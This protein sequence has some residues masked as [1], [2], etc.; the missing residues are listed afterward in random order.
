MRVLIALL[1][2]VNVAWADEWDQEESDRYLQRQYDRIDSIFGKDRRPRVN[3]YMLEPLEPPRSKE[4][5]RAREMI[6]QNNEQALFKQNEEMIEELQKLN[7][8]RGVLD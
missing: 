4:E 6:R 7:R 3:S 8:K 2:M 1:C 5:W